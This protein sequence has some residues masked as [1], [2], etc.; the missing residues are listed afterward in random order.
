MNS[1]RRH[2]HCHATVGCDSRGDALLCNLPPPTHRENLNLYET[3]TTGQDGN[4]TIRGVAPGDY[5]ILAWED[6]EPNAW[7]NADFLKPLES[8]AQ[9]VTVIGTS[10]IDLSLRVR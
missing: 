9:R 4:F 3:A 10:S 7:L 2:V 1:I 6:I 5:G 8:Q